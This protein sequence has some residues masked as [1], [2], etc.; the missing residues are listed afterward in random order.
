MPVPSRRAQRCPPSAVRGGSLR[1]TERP[2]ARS[3]ERESGVRARIASPSVTGCTRRRTAPGHS[4]S[5][6]R[7]AVAGPPHRRRHKRR[8]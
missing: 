3:R 4:H 2:R 7:A 5:R 1:R 8:R 6:P